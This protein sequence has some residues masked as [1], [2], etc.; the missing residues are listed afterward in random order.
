MDRD[1][2][3]IWQMAWDLNEL[4]GDLNDTESLRY[5][6]YTLMIVLSRL[7]HLLK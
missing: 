5:Y 2:V 7:F 1:W 3:W 6:A 4:M